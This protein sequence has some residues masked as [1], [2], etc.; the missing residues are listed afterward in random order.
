MI[1]RPPRSTRTDTLFPYTTLFRSTIDS[2]A[3]AGQIR[4]S[5]LE[6]DIARLEA[7]IESEGGK[8]LASLAAAAAEEADAATQ[9]L[10]RLDE[11]AATVKML[12]DVL[13]EA[14]A[15]ASRTFVGPVAQRARVHVEDRKSTRLN[16]SH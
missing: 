3:R 16:S 13:D 9:A 4:R 14:R 12:K 1:R 8:G 5:D 10:A 2:R 11:E 7:I 6:K 15:E